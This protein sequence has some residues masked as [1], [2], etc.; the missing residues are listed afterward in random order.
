MRKTSHS[1][2]IEESDHNSTVAP[3]RRRAPAKENQSYIIKSFFK[4]QTNSLGHS[5][6]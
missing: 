1:V 4:A 3:W 2:E 5:S 6:L